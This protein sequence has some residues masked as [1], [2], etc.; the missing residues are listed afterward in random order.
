MTKQ[1]KIQEVYGEQ[2]SVYKDDIDLN[3]GTLNDFVI[4][5]DEKMS[6]WVLSNCI[7]IK[8]DGNGG[9]SWLPIT[10]QG[11]ENNNGWIKI[12]SESDLPKE[13]G[14]YWHYDDGMVWHN[15]WDKDEIKIGYT[16]KLI[17]H[18]KPITKPQPPL[19]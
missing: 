5:H 16:Q 12:E 8:Q 3:D 6:I 18:Y 13:D 19:Y 17:T 11:I 1:E 9:F 7:R 14:A 15:P 2:W 10:L 4:G